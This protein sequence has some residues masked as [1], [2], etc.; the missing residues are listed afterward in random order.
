MRIVA[1]LLA[2]PLLSACG[3]ATPI[4]GPTVTVTETVTQGSA[5]PEVEVA[6]PPSEGG[7]I[8]AAPPADLC[9][10]LTKADAE[11]L[12]GTAL[13]DAT[14]AGPP[15]QAPT[16]CQYTGDP[17]GP[18]AQVDLFVGDGALKFLETDRDTLGHVFTE[19]PGI[20]DEAQQED[21]AI[22]F[23]VGPTWYAISLVRL[24][25]PAAFVTPLQD[26]ARTVV[27]RASSS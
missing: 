12:A 21:F 20:G 15:G 9:A 14:P 5:A 3:S 4:A 6:A 13:L 10:L 11:T 2:L 7:S 25:D 1:L 8:A 24:E 19:V 26:A 22:F 17:T 16:L 27:G 23:R 18:T